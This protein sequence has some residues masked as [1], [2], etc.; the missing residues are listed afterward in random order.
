M[1]QLQQTLFA[2]V[3]E[4]ASKAV[5]KIGANGGFTYIIDLSS[6][7]LVYKGASGIDLLPEAKK[8]LGIPA[9]KT[10]PTQFNTQPAE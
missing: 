8:E 9:E 5:E 7:V 3:Y 10:Q 1:Q 6:G 4:K 2:P